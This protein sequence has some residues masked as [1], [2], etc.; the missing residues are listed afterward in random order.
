M[1]STSLASTSL[2][3]P[4]NRSTGEV[5]EQAQRQAGVTEYDPEAESVTIRLTW[6]A[7]QEFGWQQ[8]SKTVR[9]ELVHAWQYWQ[10][11]EVDHGETFA[12]WTDPLDIAQH[13]ERF[14][15]PKWWLVC[16]DCGQ[17]IGR[18]RRSQTVCNPEY[19]QCGDCSGNLRV[20]VGP[21][22]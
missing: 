20:E 7:Y 10:F 8:F 3:S 18:Y 4:S 6:D 5:S 19:Y 2:S 16:G 22:Q 11:E 13:C 12:R 1:R 14:I 15:S 17:R 9:H 21:G